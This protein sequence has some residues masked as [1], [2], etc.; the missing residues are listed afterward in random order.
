ML[1]GKMKN[2]DDYGF[3]FESE[4]EMFESYVVIDDDYH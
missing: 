4:G 1:Y 3:R 2:S